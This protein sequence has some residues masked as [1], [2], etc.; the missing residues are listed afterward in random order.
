MQNLIEYCRLQEAMQG[1][2][3]LSGANQYL[4]SHCQSKVDATRQLCVKS[5][6]PLL[7]LSLQRFVFDMKV[8]AF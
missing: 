6:P 3:L 5:L 2:E 4:C 8:N 1:V 7:C